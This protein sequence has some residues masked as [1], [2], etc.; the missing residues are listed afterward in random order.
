MPD[1]ITRYLESFAEA[2]AAGGPDP[3]SAALATVDAEG[4]PSCRMVL[5][6]YADPRGFVFFTNLSSPKARSLTDGVLDARAADAGPG[7]SSPSV[8]FDAR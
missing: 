3:K 4:R 8:T 5:I 2:G 6:Q 1:P 7:W